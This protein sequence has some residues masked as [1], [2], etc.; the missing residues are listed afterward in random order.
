VR[1][2]VLALLRVLLLGSRIEST[3]DP[4]KLLYYGCLGI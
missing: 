4:V 1:K 2:K 3:P